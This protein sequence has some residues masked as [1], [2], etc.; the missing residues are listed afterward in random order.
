M[1]FLQTELL[2]HAQKVCRLY[3]AGLR[4]LRSEHTQRHLMRYDATLLRNRF[5]VNAVIDDPIVA[6]QVLEEG[7][8]ELRRKDHPLPFKFPNSPGGCA[9]GREPF[10]PDAIFDMWHPLEKAQYPEYFARREQRKQEYVDRWE[11][12]YG[13]SEAKP[14]AA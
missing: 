6:T 4:A 14:S 11:K 9:Y 12:K 10:L 2:S 13:G 5:D 8:E 1:S 3:R 7:M